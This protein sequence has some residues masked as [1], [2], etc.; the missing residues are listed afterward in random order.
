MP[1]ALRH[2]LLAIAI[3]A[4]PAFAAA[5]TYPSGTMQHPAA[6]PTIAPSAATQNSVNRSA[7]S[8]Y[9]QAIAACE[10]KPMSERVAC[11]QAAD[12]QF[13]KGG[14]ETS[15]NTTSGGAT[16]NAATGNAT[17]GSTAGA[18]G[19][20][21][22]SGSTSSGMGSTSGNASGGMGSTGSTGSTGGTG[23]SSGTGAAGGTGGGTK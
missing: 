7:N 6:T 14:G 22:T 10:Q 21:T 11:R 2:T 18:T 3:S 8:D 23:S 13:G 15:G 4:L 19:T 20:G 1:R 17:S 9:G 5:Q 12:S 16:G